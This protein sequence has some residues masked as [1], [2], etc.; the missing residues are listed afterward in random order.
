MRRN[1]GHLALRAKIASGLKKRGMSAELA[2]AEASRRMLEIRQMQPG[3]KFMVAAGDEMI[4]VT[5]VEGED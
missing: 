3:Q 2:E 1:D 4:E 5:T